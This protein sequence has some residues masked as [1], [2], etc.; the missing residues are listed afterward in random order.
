A[1]LERGYAVVWDVRDG[2]ERLVTARAEGE[3][4]KTLEIQFRD[5]RLPVASARRRKSQGAA[6][7]PEQGR[8]L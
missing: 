4:A 2:E 1:T 3:A 6:P 5:G 8:L 7:P